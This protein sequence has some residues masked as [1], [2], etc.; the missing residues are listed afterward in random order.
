MDSF[1]WRGNGEYWF[2]DD[3][4]WF[5]KLMSKAPLGIPFSAMSAVGI[6]SWHAGKWLAGRPIVQIDWRN[7]QGL[8]LTSGVGLGCRVFAE[9]LKSEL[10]R[11]FG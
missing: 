11:G 6:G 5:R 7:Q 9:E 3:A 4:F 2:T 10:E 8:S 1:G